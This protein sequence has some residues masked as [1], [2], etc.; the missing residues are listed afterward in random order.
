MTLRFAS[1][2]AVA[3]SFAAAIACS[4]GAGSGSS[5]H[6]TTGNPVSTGG[7]T[8]LAVGDGMMTTSDPTDTRDLTKRQKVC[9]SAGNCSCLRLAMLGTLTSSAV[10]SDTM[11]FVTWLNSKSMGTATV[12]PV[13]DKPTIDATFLADYDILVVANVNTW[14]LSADEKA[15]VQKW[16]NDTGGGIITL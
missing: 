6:S 12:T 4:A 3:S 9:D 1:A 5:S 2:L 10:D 14:T 8:G 15:A 7:G 16:S 13:P 11:A